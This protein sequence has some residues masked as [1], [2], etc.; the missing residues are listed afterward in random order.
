MSFVFEKLCYIDGMLF[1]H[2]LVPQAAVKP[3]SFVGLMSVYETRL[4]GFSNRKVTT[5]SRF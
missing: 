3:G 2:E 5:E 4:I 1:D